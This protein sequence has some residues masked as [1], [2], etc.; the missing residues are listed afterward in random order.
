MRNDPI[1]TTFE[2]FKAVTNEDTMKDVLK[3]YNIT[4][5]REV[6]KII[7]QWKAKQGNSR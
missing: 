7:V 3:S 6:A 4:E 2:D 5:P 1:P